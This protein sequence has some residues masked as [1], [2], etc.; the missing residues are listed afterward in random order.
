MP[1]RPFFRSARTTS[2]PSGPGSALV[3]TSSR[4][5]AGHVFQSASTRVGGASA[6][7]ER[8]AAK[9]YA[10]NAKVNVAAPIARLP[11]TVLVNDFM[12]VL[13]PVLS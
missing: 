8:S 10:V 12:S 9:R 7:F 5:V 6:G 13:Q 2:Q 3:W 11:D 4:P 1:D